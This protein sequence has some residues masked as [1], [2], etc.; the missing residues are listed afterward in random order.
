MKSA[1]ITVIALRRIGRRTKTGMFALSAVILALATSFP[2]LFI[3]ITS[4]FEESP[5]L[6][7]GVVMG[8]NIANI[9]LVAGITALVAGKVKVHG[10]FLKR[11]VWIALVA[12]ILPVILIIDSSLNRVD[13]LILLAVY[14][15]YSTSFFRGRFLE[16]AQEHKKEGFIYRYLRKFNHV[17]SEKTKEFGRLFVGIALLLAS[18]DIIVRIS[19]QAALVAGIP[20]FVLGLV[21]VAIGTSLP[22]LV[23]SLRSISDREP[24]MF[25]GNLLGSTIVNSTLIVGITAFIHPISLPNKTMYLIPALTFVVVY[26]FF[27][28]FIKTKMT[29]DRGEA[30]FLLLLYCFF[31]ISEFLL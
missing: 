29:L 21:A 12:G 22:E 31:V 5:N 20:I 23:F 17:D 9:S 14:A 16:I 7:L 24:S 28:H 10:S 26:M 27:W 15:A 3:G 6:T 2:E 13:G 4:A 8:S 1:D 18:S 30:V 25:F 19:T 11:D